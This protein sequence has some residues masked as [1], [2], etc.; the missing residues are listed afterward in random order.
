MADDDAD[1]PALAERLASL[2]AARARAR[3]EETAAPA[4]RVHETGHTFRVAWE[5]TE[6]VEER[7]QILARALD[8]VEVAPSPVRGR[9]PV[10]GR[11]EI[12]WRVDYANLQDY[13]SGESRGPANG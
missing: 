8:A 9:S 12:R 6:D 2:K 13:G 4:I 5:A 7:R 1:V 10:E 3:A 11:V